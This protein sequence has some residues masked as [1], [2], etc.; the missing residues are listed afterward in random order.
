MKRRIL[1]PSVVRALERLRLIAD[2][3]ASGPHPVRCV[4]RT[5]A[6]SKHSGVEVEHRQ[7]ANRRPSASS[8]ATKSML[9]MSS[10]PV[11]G[12]AA[13]G[14][15]R[16]HVATAACDA[17][18]ILPRCTRDRSARRRPPNLSVISDP[19]SAMAEAH[20]RLGKLQHGR[21]QGDQGIFACGSRRRTESRAGR[22]APGGDYLI[23]ARQSVHDFALFDGLQNLFRETLSRERSATRRFSFLGVFVL[24]LLQRARFT[25]LQIPV[26]LL[27]AM[28]RL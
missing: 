6:M 7:R 15:R 2:A 22:D 25:R 5:T 26:D 28:L 1:T 13:P 4:P 21:P 16:S 23:S 12:H 10:R 17:M 11:G 27:P 20:S 19:E 14:A 3:R 18:P 24:Q 8:S 9:K